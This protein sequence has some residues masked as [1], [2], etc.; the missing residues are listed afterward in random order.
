MAF[1]GLGACPLG[2]TPIGFGIYTSLNST[3][4]K[5]YQDNDGIIRNAEKINIETG[6]VEYDQ[7]TGIP[8]GMD[9]VQQMVYLALRTVQ[10]SSIIPTFGLKFNLKTINSST[11]QKI[12]QA[13]EG[14]LANLVSRRLIEIV[15]ITVDRIKLNAI[16]YQLKWKNLTNNETT[17][18]KFELSRVS[19]TT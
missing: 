18:D 6:Q 9:S 15:E 1:L 5:L 17:L 7:E 12:Q 11:K 16:F 19:S 10:G 2:S 14:A 4:G 8:K 3:A 13:V